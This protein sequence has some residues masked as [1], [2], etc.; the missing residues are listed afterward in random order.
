MFTDRIFTI[1]LLI[2]A[3][4][5]VVIF[6]VNP[7]LNPFISKKEE[8]FI[9]VNYLDNALRAVLEQKKE[10]PEKKEALRRPVSTI[11]VKKLAPPPFID[12]D[13]FLKP[14]NVVKTGEGA[15]RKPSFDRPDIGALKKKITLPPIDID[16]DKI[17]NPTYISYY[18]MV[19]EKIRRAAYHIY[20]H[21]ETG[22]VYLSFIIASDG[23]LR[24]SRLVE[25]R[26]TPSRYLH[27]LALRSVKDASPF[28]VFPPGLDH[29]QL[30][31]NVVISFEIE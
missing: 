7:G 14:D 24:E 15:M 30:S 8:K 19:R 28:P 22:D 23:S 17:N 1:T 4:V 6:A 11:D 16:I 12:K 18:Q 31:F 3:G 13:V 29:P 21:A 27:E 25:E 5:H 9:E 20:T 10:K 26:S 2:S